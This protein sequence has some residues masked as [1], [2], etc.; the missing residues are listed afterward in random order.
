MNIISVEVGQKA[1]VELSVDDLIE[2]CNALYKHEKAKN[3]QL[4]ADMLLCK[5]ICKYGKIDNNTLERFA[6]KRGFNLVI[7]PESNLQEES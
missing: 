6:S 1:T 2:I 4:S 7:K 5:D 3:I